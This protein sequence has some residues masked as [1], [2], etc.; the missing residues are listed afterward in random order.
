ME[1]EFP[2]WFWYAMWAMWSVFA[3]LFA[4]IIAASKEMRRYTERA[5][6]RREEHKNQVEKLKG[7]IMELA[8]SLGGKCV[9]C[10]GYGCTG[11]EGQYDCFI[12][13]GTGLRDLSGFKE[14]AVRII[15]EAR[16]NLARTIDKLAVIESEITTDS[17]AS[18]SQEASA[19]HTQK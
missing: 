3:P 19:K 8:D 13:G 16:H 11:E 10:K 12:C 1:N 17:N 5:L 6:T 7:R 18:T 14:E 15:N 2:I 9:V 4:Y